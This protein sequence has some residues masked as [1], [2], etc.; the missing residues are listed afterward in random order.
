MSERERMQSYT[1]HLIHLNL[2]LQTKCVNSEQGLS[3]SQSHMYNHKN[4]Q[5]PC[6]D[7][8][9]CAQMSL[10]QWRSVLSSPQPSPSHWSEPR[11]QSRA[12]SPLLL[13]ILPDTRLPPGKHRDGGEKKDGAME[14]WRQRQRRR[15]HTVSTERQGWLLWGN[16]P[17]QPWPFPCVW[18]RSSLWV[19]QAGDENKSKHEPRENGRR[20]SGGV[21]R[22]R[23][24][25]MTLQHSI[26]YSP[27]Q[28][29]AHRNISCHKLHFFYFFGHNILTIRTLH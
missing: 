17:I 16:L 22:V 24:G 3:T 29:M 4:T 2:N 27:W 25:W 26:A 1:N 15:A 19:R 8:L 10:R 20:G 18:S 6:W 23:R 21:E 13:P 14:R 11:L 28:S 9:V 5:A 7:M 12:D